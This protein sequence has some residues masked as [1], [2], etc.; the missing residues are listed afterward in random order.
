MGN[1]FY[2]YFVKLWWFWLVVLFFAYQVFA[3]TGGFKPSKWFLR[4]Q[5]EGETRRE[6]RLKKDKEDR[7]RLKV[8]NR[9]D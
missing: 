8:K 6:Q 5:I 4:Q 9:D 1:F 2:T 3:N 7:E